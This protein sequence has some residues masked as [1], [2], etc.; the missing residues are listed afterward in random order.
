MG[1]L[2]VDFNVLKRGKTVYQYCFASTN[3][4]YGEVF[5]L[6][7]YTTASIYVDQIGRSNASAPAPVIKSESAAPPSST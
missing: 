4:S 7:N 3:R 1:G 6:E 2:W 5:L